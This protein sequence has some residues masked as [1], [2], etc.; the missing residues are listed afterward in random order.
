MKIVKQVKEQIKALPIG[1]PFSTV[2]LPSFGSPENIRKILSRLVQTGEIKR[3]THGIFIKPKTSMYVGEVLPSLYEVAQAI[4][5]NTGEK[6]AIHGAEAARRLRLT[7]QVPMQTIFSTSGPSR[8]IRV[9]NREIKLQHVSSRKLIASSTTRGDVIS[10]LWY[11][12]KE[13]VS[14]ATI[15]VIKQQLNE[16]EFNSVLQELPKMPAWM[17]KQFYVYQNEAVREY[18]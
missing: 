9:G 4:A 7:T 11:L 6:I 16:E 15:Q 8:T 2:D 3:V 5:K 14:Q 1:K 13:K 12:G 18:L 10:A 17:A